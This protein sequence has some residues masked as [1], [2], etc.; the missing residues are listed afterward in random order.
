[1]K[2]FLLALCLIVTSCATQQ[3]KVTEKGKKRSV[4]SYEGK[5]HFIFWGLGQEK[6]VNALEACN[7]GQSIEAVD[8]HLTFVDGLL[9]AITY[10]IYYP[11]SYRI[12]CSKDKSAS[13]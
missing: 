9:S 3:F 4:P 12:Y 13:K 10:G 6:E 11:R 7:E 8:T 2:M 1:M 5:H